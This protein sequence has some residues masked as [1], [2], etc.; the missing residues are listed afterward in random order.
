MCKSRS[1]FQQSSCHGAGN[2]VG[3]SVSFPSF[4]DMLIHFQSFGAGA[5]L[6][7]T[8]YSLVL[9]AVARKWQFAGKHGGK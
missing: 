8:R 5:A 3:G 1:H 2:G 4:L 9:K 6:F 7:P